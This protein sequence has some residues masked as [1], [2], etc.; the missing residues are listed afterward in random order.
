MPDFADIIPPLAPPPA[1]PPYGWI[2]FGGAVLL[3]FALGWLARASFRS[4][5]KRRA[6]A[7]I[8]NA[9]RILQQGQINPRLALF[10]AHAALAL[11]YPLAQAGQRTTPPASLAEIH[12]AQWRAFVSDLDQARFAAGATSMQDAR[13]LLGSAQLWIGRMPC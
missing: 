11:V 4:R 12:H 6:L 8:R 10:A 13:T 3:A 1:A 7:Q 5:H 2:I 9:E